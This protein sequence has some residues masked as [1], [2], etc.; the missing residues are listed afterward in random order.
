MITGVTLSCPQCAARYRV[1]LD[2]TKLR[3]VR[4]RARCSHCGASFDVA[5]AMGRLEGSSGHPTPAQP[6]RAPSLTP[7]RGIRSLTPSRGVRSL[8]P[9]TRS[10]TPAQGR[11]RIAAISGRMSRPEPPASGEGQAPDAPPSPEAPGGGTDALRGFSLP[12]PHAKPGALTLSDVPDVPD[13]PPSVDRPQDARP[14]LPAS[15]L[16]WL[17]HALL[18]LDRLRAEPSEGERALDRLLDGATE[19]KP[20]R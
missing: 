3:H 18:P 16:L 15:T 10:L 1:R 11:A 14:E 20:P 8:T 6:V 19:P 2:L 7:A 4:S 5:E 9:A 13:A 17:E 12:A